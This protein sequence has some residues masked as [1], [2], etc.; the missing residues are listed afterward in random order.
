MVRLRKFILSSCPTVTSFASHT[1]AFVLTAGKGFLSSDTAVPVPDTA[2]ALRLSALAW[3]RRPWC[4][5]LRRSSN[6]PHQE[7][8]WKFASSSG[9]PITRQVGIWANGRKRAEVHHRLSKLVRVTSRSTRKQNSR[10]RCTSVYIP[11]AKSFKAK[12]DGCH[13]LKSKRLAI[14]KR[15]APPKRF[16]CAAC[17]PRFWATMEWKWLGSASHHAIKPEYLLCAL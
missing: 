6:A 12:I 1:S 8:C 3:D 14:M 11:S 7:G 9:H 2:P 15:E 17:M 5:I 13:H 4:G 16:P 10:K